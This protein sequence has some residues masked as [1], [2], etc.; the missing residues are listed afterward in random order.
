MYNSVHRQHPQFLYEAMLI[1]ISV[2]MNKPSLIQ[3][4]TKCKPP[5][6]LHHILCPHQFHRL[7]IQLIHCLQI[8][9]P[10]IRSAPAR[11][12]FSLSRQNRHGIL[13]A[14][15]VGGVTSIFDERLNERRC[16]MRIHRT[17][18]EAA[19]AIDTRSAVP[20]GIE[21]TGSGEE[22]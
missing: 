2:R 6:N 19:D 16:G 11:Q 18:A 14:M 20:E 17:L 21:I 1:P 5:S 15:D 13:S 10:P 3:S 12:H 7:Q 9:Q 4:Q 8:P 22:G